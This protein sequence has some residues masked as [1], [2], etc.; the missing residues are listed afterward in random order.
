MY[1]QS[2]NILVLPTKHNK[3]I[4][5]NRLSN[6]LNMLVNVVLIKVVTLIDYIALVTDIEFYCKISFYQNKYKEKGLKLHKIWKEL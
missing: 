3:E 6:T 4:I 5:F 1:L 2:E